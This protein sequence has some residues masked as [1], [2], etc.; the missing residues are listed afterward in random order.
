[1]KFD[2]YQGK[3]SALEHK[4]ADFGL[5]ERVVLEMTE[6]YWGQ[7]R[8]IY[9]DN[10]FNSLRLLEKLKVENT[11]ACGTI[12]SNRK[13]LPN[14]FAQDKTMKRGNFDYR[15]S[16]SNIGAFKWKDN[17]SVYFA[18]NFHGS[19]TTSVNRKQKDGSS[20]SIQCPT[21]VKD[22]NE[23]ISGVDHADRYIDLMKC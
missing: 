4:Y 16:S 23:H 11:L 21:V 14:N 5:G 3:N 9:F 18:S 2:V 6:K 7:N 20:L 1:M 15:F 12:R 13:G 17:R 10:Y 8:K 22:Y 19:D